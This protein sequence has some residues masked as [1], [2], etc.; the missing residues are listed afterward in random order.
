MPLEK[1][2]VG[3]ALSEK[4]REGPKVIFSRML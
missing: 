2:V 3:V 1:S 4:A